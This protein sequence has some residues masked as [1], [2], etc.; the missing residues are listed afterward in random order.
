MPDEATEDG[1]DTQMQ[2]NHLSH[3]LLTR[4]LFPLLEKSADKHGDARIVNREAE[5][6]HGRS[7]GGKQIIRRASVDEDLGTALGHVG[8]GRTDQHQRQR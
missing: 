3:F 7:G 8:G 5:L 4:E 2:T 6:L 1:F